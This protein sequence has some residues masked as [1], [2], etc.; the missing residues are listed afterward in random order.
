MM[1]LLQVPNQ[2]LMS[3][4]INNVT[5]SHQLQDRLIFEVD[6]VNFTPELCVDLANRIAVLMEHEQNR[7]LFD[8]E[9]VP[10][11]YIVA[12]TNPLKYQVCTE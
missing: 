7:H 11:S 12:V 2:T 6:S 10:F 3:S 1:W 5:Q 8:V 4:D 9:F